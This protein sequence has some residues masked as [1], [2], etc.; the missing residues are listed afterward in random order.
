MKFLLECMVIYPFLI[1]KKKGLHKYKEYF[2]KTKVYSFCSLRLLATRI[3]L[4]KK[5][6]FFL[7]TKEVGIVRV[8]PV[9]WWTQMTQLKQVQLWLCQRFIYLES[10]D[11]LEV[12]ISNDPLS[13]A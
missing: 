12:M 3:S 4:P 1:K 11:L 13:E 6:F 7:I 10:L 8:K 5:K 9:I 2:M